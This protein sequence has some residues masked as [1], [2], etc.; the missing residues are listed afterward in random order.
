MRWY[1][2][3]FQKSQNESIIEWN[4]N[5]WKFRLISY[6][7]TSYAGLVGTLVNLHPTKKCFWYPWKGV[8]VPNVS[9]ERLG[10][11]AKSK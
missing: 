10:T 2:Y 5:Y 3:N 8:I 4:F 7:R 9:I 6:S 11:Q 1:H